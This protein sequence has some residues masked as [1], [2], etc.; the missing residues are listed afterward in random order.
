MAGLVE[1]ILAGMPNDYQRKNGTI[2][3]RHIDEQINK[4]HIK[5]MNDYDIHYTNTAERVITPYSFQ[6]TND[7]V[8]NSNA[9]T[10]YLSDA[11][12]FAIY[13]YMKNLVEG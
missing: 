13:K 11:E 1:N 5:I 4:V 12:M 9:H 8:P 3:V 7:N 2:K 10:K 6:I